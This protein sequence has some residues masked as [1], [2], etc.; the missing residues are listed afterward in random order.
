[1]DNNF[2][3]TSNL[4]E[5]DI[6]WIISHLRQTYWASWRSEECITESL[7][8]S[9]CFGLFERE[10][11][12]E[13]RRGRTHIDKQ[14]GFGRVVTDFATVSNIVDIYIDM[15][16]RRKGL[17]KFLMNA[18][19]MDPRIKNTVQLLRTRPATEIFY[20]RLGFDRVIAYRKIPETK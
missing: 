11:L 13:T 18:I 6:N 4:A 7:R 8:N 3:V 20:T 12:P 5:L 17:G 10:V 14:V 19:C 1:M 2:Y 16:Y 9:L 15:D